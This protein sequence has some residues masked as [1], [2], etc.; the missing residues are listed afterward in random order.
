MTELSDEL[1]VAYV[2][3]Q[4]A[5][6]QSKAVERVLENDEVAA[7][8]VHALRA[9]HSQ[10]ETAFEAMLQNEAD[11]LTGMS[12]VAEPAAQTP[13]QIAQPA[14]AAAGAELSEQE[15]QRVE[16][17]QPAEAVQIAAGSEGKKRSPGFLLLG[18]LAIAFTLAGGVGGYALRGTPDPATLVPGA[19]V[20]VV[21]GAAAQRD[22]QEDLII[23]HSLFGRDTLTLTL[24]TQSNPDLIAF[25]L[26]N[27][28]G[29]ELIIPDLSDAGLAFKRAQLLHRGEEAVAQISYLPEEGEPVSLYARWDK[30]ADAPVRARQID[31]VS[32]A[33]WRQGNI[34]YLLAAHVPLERIGAL[35]ELARRQIGARNAVSSSLVVPMTAAEARRNADDPG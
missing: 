12:E 10:L 26:A 19:I 13:E 8:R 29:S 28:I 1:L 33:Q 34:T 32:A 5:K 18:G 35:G 6:D 21:T 17:V 2:D 7:Q 11:A 3:G 14:E 15:V 31:G 23:A 22:W 30:G 4:L 9:A 24:E 27:A 16:P 20:P 25:Q